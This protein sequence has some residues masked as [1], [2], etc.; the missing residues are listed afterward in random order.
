[1]VGRGKRDAIEISRG[2]TLGKGSSDSSNNVGNQGAK[3]GLGKAEDE[4]HGTNNKV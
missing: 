1:M 3:E 4:G 2:T